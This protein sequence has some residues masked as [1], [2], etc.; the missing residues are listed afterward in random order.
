MVKCHRGQGYREEPQ[1]VSSKCIYKK[2]NVQI[3]HLNH[4]LEKI[5]TR[6]KLKSKD[7]EGIIN[8]KAGINERENRREKSKSWCFKSN[9]T[10]CSRTDNQGMARE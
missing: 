8:I 4:H 2:R 10:E 6:E 5:R 7:A 9:K 1:N 3:S